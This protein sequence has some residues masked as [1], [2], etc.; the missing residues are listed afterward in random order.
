MYNYS[1]ANVHIFPDG[2]YAQDLYNSQSKKYKISRNPPH[3]SQIIKD[4]NALHDEYNQIDE[5]LTKKY[6]PKNNISKTIGNYIFHSNYIPNYLSSKSSRR[7]RKGSAGTIKPAKSRLNSHQRFAPLIKQSPNISIYK[8]TGRKEPIQSNTDII[9]QDVPSDTDLVLQDL[10]SYTE[11]V[12]H[13][14]PLIQGIQRNSDNI[15]QTNSDNIRQRNSD[16]VHQINSDNVRQRNSDNVRQ[17]NSDNIR[18]RNSNNIRQRNSENIRQRNSENIRQ[19]N[20]DNIRQRNSENIRQI[21]SDNIRQRNSNNISK[22]NSDGLYGLS[23]DNRNSKSLDYPLYGFHQRNSDN[24]RQTNSDKYSQT[25]SDNIRQINSDNYRQINSDKYRQTNSYR[26]RQKNSDNIRQFD[27]DNVRQ[28]NLQTLLPSQVNP[29]GGLPSQVNPNGFLPETV[30]LNGVC[31]LTDESKQ[32]L[33]RE[34]KE[35]P[36]MDGDIKYENNN[37]YHENNN[38]YHEDIADYHEDIADYHENNNDYSEDEY[39]DNGVVPMESS[40]TIYNILYP[41]MSTLMNPKYHVPVEDEIIKPVA[42]IKSVKYHNNDMNNESITNICNSPLDY[43]KDEYN[44]NKLLSI[45]ENN[46]SDIISN[47]KSMQNMLNFLFHEIINENND[48]YNNDNDQHNKNNKGSDFNKYQK[49]LQIEKYQ[50]PI[51]ENTRY[52]QIKKG[53]YSNI[54]VS[55]ENNL[56]NEP[57]WLM[58]MIGNLRPDEQSN[59]SESHGSYY[60]KS[61]DPINVYD[62]NNISSNDSHEVTT[63]NNIDI[64]ERTR[65]GSNLKSLALDSDP[66]INNKINSEGTMLIEQISPLRSTREYT[67]YPKSITNTVYINDT[68]NLNY[69]IEFLK[70]DKA[71]Y[72]KLKEPV[73][74]ILKPPRSSHMEFAPKII[75]HDPYLYINIGSLEERREI[76]ESVSS[77]LNEVNV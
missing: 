44:L 16:N 36:Y 26:Y 33:R 57:K 7:K 67:R 14:M 3:S 72:G 30:N 52:N 77:I 27:S 48:Q 25:N 47:R 63:I 40:G 76:Y 20:S 39:S 1:D 34:T 10:P 32:L 23:I 29:N 5:S 37:D 8:R 60:Y 75:H 54:V 15:S 74:S 71:N 53:N 35:F 28:R 61:S 50:E 46:K 66:Y 41:I 59:T 2:L 18:K 69:P 17:R 22:I 51:T 6:N 9:F 55:N 45:R 64:S 4:N 62:E 38:D 12:L 70:D 24:Y 49:D 58:D 56:G 21:N 42:P 31:I 13:D 68:E 11:S 73:K 19:I 65:K 43:V